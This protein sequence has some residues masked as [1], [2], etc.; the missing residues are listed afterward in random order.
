M[1]IYVALTTS[2]IIGL[3]ID[4]DL[5]DYQPIIVTGDQLLASSR[6]VVRSCDLHDVIL[7]HCQV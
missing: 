5:I 3:W 4:V 6:L 7:W 2:W 1:H